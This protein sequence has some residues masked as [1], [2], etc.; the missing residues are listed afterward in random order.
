MKRTVLVLL[1][2]GAAGL[3]AQSP[4]ASAV[5][6]WN[7]NA[8]EEGIS[9]YRVSVSRT[10]VEGPPQVLDAG[11]VTQFKVTGLTPGAPYVFALQAYTPD[12]S[13]AFTAPLSWTPSA[14]YGADGACAPMAGS[15]PEVS[16]IV[17]AYDLT[18]KRSDPRGLHVAFDA[19]SSE[20]IVRIEMD[21]EGDGEPAIPLT[22]PAGLGFDGRYI[23]GLNF[24]PTVNGTWPLLVSATDAVGRKATA[25][26][27]P[28]VT[29]GF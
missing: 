27:L 15:A 25:R 10:D 7:A 9:G 13:S 24:K 5:L 20:P 17:Q 21:M 4:A 28:G 23:R 11:N 22:F 3:Q 19:G 12:S 6:G 26:C 1:L 29:V 18:A 2:L 8:P 14:P 16:V